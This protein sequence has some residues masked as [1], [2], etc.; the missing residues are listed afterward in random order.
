MRLGEIARQW[1]RR[2][3]IFERGGHWYFRTREGIDVGPYASRFEAEIEADILIARLA[4]DSSLQ[5]P[6]IIRS[7]ILESIR[8]RSSGPGQVDIGGRLPV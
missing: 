5:A 3:R 8:Q 7:F 4:R 6:H 1:L 2:E